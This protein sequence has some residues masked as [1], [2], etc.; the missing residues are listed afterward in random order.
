MQLIFKRYTS[1]EYDTFKIIP[2]ITH[3]LINSFKKTIK[4]YTDWWQ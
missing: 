1:K 2:S 3:D 4:K